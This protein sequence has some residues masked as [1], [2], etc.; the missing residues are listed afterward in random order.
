MKLFI[1]TSGIGSRLGDLT[2]FTNKSMIKIGK[3]P[4]ISY[5]IDEYPKDIEIVVSLGYY[6]NHVKQYL[7]LAYPDRNITFV[8][9]DNYAGP[10]SSQ[11]YSQLCAEEYLQEPF[12]YHDCDTVIDNLQAQIPMNFDHNFIVGYETNAELY[13]AFDFDATQN[14]KVIKTY[15]K[16]D[17]LEGMAAYVGI[18]GVYDYETFWRNLNKAYKEITYTAPH[19]FMVYHKYQMFANNLRAYIVDNWTDTGNV[20]SVKEARK[21]CKDSFQILD[22]IDQGIFMI[23]NQVIK[24]FAKDGVVDNLMYHYKYIAD[25]CGPIKQHTKNFIV[26]DYI[27]GEDAIKGMN[28]GRF[29]NMLKY[30]HKNNLWGEVNCID[31]EYF[32]VCKDRFYIDKTLDRINHFKSY[33]NITEDK[34]IYVNDV[35]IPKEYTIE[36]MLQ[37]F[38]QFDEYKNTVP[39]NWHGD[40]V[41]DNM[42]VKDGEFILLDW[43]EKFDDIIPFGDRNYDFAKMNHNLT[44][45]F[46]SACK[47]LFNISEK[48]DHIYVSILADNYVLACRETLKNFVETYYDVSYPYINFI[49]GLCWVNMS[50]LHMLNPVCKLLFYMGKLTMYQSL[51]AMKA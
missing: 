34:D 29:R 28:P 47:E 9:V 15:M 46:S 30:F 45:N 24:F 35:L 31:T 3:K 17:S 23:G 22:K 50:P 4:V 36:N 14:N 13:D 48:D 19:D 37:E 25:F 6:G 8:E 11:V 40:F 21:K 42:L 27:D 39:T 7:E 12:I 49:T 10:G 26:Y 38:R 32:N 51:L 2:K 16:P 33:Y 41:L 44:F 20:A 18:V 5:I 43:R 1:T